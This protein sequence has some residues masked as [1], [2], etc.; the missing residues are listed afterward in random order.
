ME[1]TESYDIFEVEESPHLKDE[2]RPC[3][4]CGAF[5]HTGGIT[6]RTGI[7]HRPTCSYLN[8][9]CLYCGNGDA[10][11][12]RAGL[13]VDVEGKAFHTECVLAW[14][15]SQGFTADE[16]DTLGEQAFG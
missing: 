14:G 8:E 12:L 13:G 2:S 1:F 5:W 15:E 7:S 16:M 3:S 10:G 6:A 9:H 11:K 4:G